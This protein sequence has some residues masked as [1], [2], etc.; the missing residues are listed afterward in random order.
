MFKTLLT[1][2]MMMVSVQAFGYELR[3]TEKGDPIRFN[4][5]QVDIVLDSSLELLG[6]IDEIEE[7]VEEMFE[8]WIDRAGLPMRFRFTS[9]NCKQF[10]YSSKGRNQNCV[11]A[12]TSDEMWERVQGGDPGATA[13]VSYKPSNG[14]IVD[15][16]IVFNAADWEWSTDGS[17]EGTLSLRAVAA[18]EIGH[19]LGLAHSDIEEAIMYPTTRVGETAAGA[20]HDDDITAANAL[21]DEIAD[22]LVDGS[23][24]DDINLADCT[25]TAAGGTPSSFGLFAG[26]LA[27]MLVRRYAS[28]IRCRVRADRS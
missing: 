28:K 5:K 6:P 11:G 22:D 3:E 9:G 8:L 10:G 21:Y 1:L 18:H 16:D 17:E 13:I 14:K 27:F 12:S 25:A 4:K 2:S 15:A 20:L 26:F 19:F 24:A 7:A 23:S